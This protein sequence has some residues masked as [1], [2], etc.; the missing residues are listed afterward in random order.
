M[1]PPKESEVCLVKYE[2]QRMGTKTDLFLGEKICV[3]H[4]GL[5]GDQSERLK[6]QTALVPVVVLSTQTQRSHGLH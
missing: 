6:R 4:L 3:Y 5:D 2:F 1:T